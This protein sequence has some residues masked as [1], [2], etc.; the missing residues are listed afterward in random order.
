[1]TSGSLVN[2]GKKP[3]YPQVSSPVNA[4]D[5]EKLLLLLPVEHGPRNCPTNSGL[6]LTLLEFHRFNHAMGT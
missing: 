5:D 2:I 1:M 3:V 4:S 6:R